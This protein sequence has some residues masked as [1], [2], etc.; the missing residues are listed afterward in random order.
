MRRPFFL[1]LLLAMV[2]SAC[3]SGAST[4]FVVNVELDDAANARLDEL[5]ESVQVIAHYYWRPASGEPAHGDNEYGYV[6]GGYPIGGETHEII[7][8]G[9]ANF[10]GRTH[11]NSHIV[12]GEGAS[13]VLIN[14]VSARQ[15]QS[16]NLLSCGIFDDSLDIASTQ[17]IDISCSLIR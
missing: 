6:L 11:S 7:G 3:D 8:S 13:R 14:V 2:A 17:G 16:N 9:R 1:A 4:P 5:G 12:V 10:D 15:T